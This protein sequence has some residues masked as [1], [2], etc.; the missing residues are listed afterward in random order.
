[1]RAVNGASHQES[2]RFD[3]MAHLR[4]AAERTI[5]GLCDVIGRTLDL[6]PPQEAPTTLLTQATMQTERKPL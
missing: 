4:K 1:M 2:F 6:Y 5:H 3:A